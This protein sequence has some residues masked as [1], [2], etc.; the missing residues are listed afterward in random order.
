MWW[1]AILLGLVKVGPKVQNFTAGDKVCCFQMD[2]PSIRSTWEII[3]ARDWSMTQVFGFAFR[4]QKEKAHQEF[5]TIPE[6]LLGKVR[7]STSVQYVGQLGLNVRGV[8]S[9]AKILLSSRL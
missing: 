1:E 4:E 8:S 3:W 6:Y 5:A 2:S 7:R 9:F